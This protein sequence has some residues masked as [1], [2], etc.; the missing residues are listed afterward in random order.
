MCYYHRATVIPLLPQR[1]QALLPGSTSEYVRVPS[2]FAEQQAAGYS[3]ANFDLEA[4]LGGDDSRTGLDEQGVAE[5]REIMRR[6][7]VK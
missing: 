2:S 5:I 6:E 4:N 3:S 7:R 1:L